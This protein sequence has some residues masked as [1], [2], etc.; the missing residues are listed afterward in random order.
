MPVVIIR[1]EVDPIVE[2][3]PSALKHQRNLPHSVVQTVA[4][5]S[6]VAVQSTSM[7]AIASNTS[8]TSTWDTLNGFPRLQSR[9]RG[10]K[11]NRY[12]EATGCK[13]LTRVEIQQVIYDYRI[14]LESFSRDP[15]GYSRRDKSLNQYIRG[16]TLIGM[17]PKGN[18]LVIAPG[19]EHNPAG[20]GTVI[21]GGGVF[22][23]VPLPQPAPGTT[24]P[25]QLFPLPTHPSPPPSPSPF[26]PFTILY[27]FD[28]Y[29]QCMYACKD[30]EAAC[31]FRGIVLC[32][33][34]AKVLGGKANKPFQSPSPPH[35][36]TPGTDCRPPIFFDC[37]YMNYLPACHKDRT[38]CE[39]YCGKKFS[40]TM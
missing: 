18:D 30:R 2:H 38:S 22:P 39:S 34:L 24:F 23:S 20:N 40:N 29:E 6:L 15:I 21:G 36:P 27:S 12:A 11:T 28:D 7:V 3:A 16:R 31:T 19:P 37:F 13:P 5:R 14:R 32:G 17:D 35:W 4:A 25:P 1:H 33:V 10:A 26:G 8:E 9:A